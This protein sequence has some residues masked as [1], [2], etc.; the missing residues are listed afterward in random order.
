M[1]DAIRIDGLAAF[2]RNLRKVDRNL[3]KA[4]RRS[5]ND[6]ADIVLDYARPKVPSRTGRARAS[7]RASST[8]KLVRV[9]AGGKR[10]PYY[11]W[12]DFGGRGPN[13]RPARRPFF[14]EGRYIY[15]GLTV[16]RKEFSV[17][18]ERALVSTARAAGIE[19][20]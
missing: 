3:P 2:T 1:P 12:L 19:V 14:K 13:G 18:L 9:S 11:G 20:D 15:K 5:M 10:V 8:P 16:K 7:L 4:L 17:A 6:A